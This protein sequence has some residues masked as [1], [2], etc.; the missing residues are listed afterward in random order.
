[1]N[2]TQRQGMSSSNGRLLTDLEHLQQSLTDLLL[3]RVG[4]RVMRRDYGCTWFELLDRPLN[5]N[6]VLQM[7]AAVVSAIERWEPRFQL[8][9]L[10]PN[11]RSISDGVEGRWWMQLRGL[12]LGK[13]ITLG[14]TV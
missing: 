8:T 14:I 5:P 11:L 13:S 1:M 10:K 9:E 4:S 7:T 3:T 2:P 6:T 12:Y